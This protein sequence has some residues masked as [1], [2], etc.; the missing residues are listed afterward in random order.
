MGEVLSLRPRPD[1]LFCIDDSIAVGA[2]V[3]IFE[4]GL[5]IPEEYRNRGLAL[6][7]QTAS[8]CRLSVGG[9]TNNKLRF[10]YYS[11]VSGTR[12]RP[13]ER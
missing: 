9:R 2:M 1:A 13:Q 8:P 4:A 12:L 6:P 5:R 11:R 3:K 10:N 7:P